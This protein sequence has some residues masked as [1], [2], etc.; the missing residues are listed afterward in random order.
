M[1]TI[2]TLLILSIGLSTA[3]YGQKK[4]GTAIPSMGAA[5]MNN[6]AVKEAI[7]NKQGGTYY[8]S[9]SHSAT[10]I[11][12]TGK[13]YTIVST[14]TAVPHT[15]T[16]VGYTTT[17]KDTLFLSNDPLGLLIKECWNMDTNSKYSG[18]MPVIVM[19]SNLDKMVAIRKANQPKMVS[20]KK[21]LKN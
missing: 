9:S 15:G 5:Y 14:Q 12:E 20:D 3:A 13:T 1:K 21:I 6:E 16:L 7:K 17:A 19:V 4:A 8:S 18:K 2:Y 10:V 11:T